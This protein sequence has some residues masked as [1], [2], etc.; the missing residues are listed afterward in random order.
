M[1]ST[2]LHFLWN[3]HA[4][5][6]PFRTGVSLHSHTMCSQEDVLFLPKMAYRV[7]VLVM[8]LT[9]TAFIG[10]RRWLR[11]KPSLWKRGN[12]KSAWGLLALFRSRITMK[13]K[14][15]CSCTC[16]PA[17]SR[18]L[19]RSNGPYPS[20]RRSSI[21][22]ST[23]F[24]ANMPGRWLPKWRCTPISPHRPDCPNC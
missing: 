15:A 24:R 7:P 2:P 14:P 8:K 12:W 18:F 16:S 3:D 5:A 9:T 17:L 23:I 11:A 6:R 21:W 13:S 10:P 19:F 22:E 1:K 4:A 20:A